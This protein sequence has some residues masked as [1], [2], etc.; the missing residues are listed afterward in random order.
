MNLKSANPRGDEKVFANNIYRADH[1]GNPG[2][3]KVAYE[4]SSLAEVQAVT[5]YMNKTS[6]KSYSVSSSIGANGSITVLTGAPGVVKFA[7]GQNIQAKISASTSVG[8]DIKNGKSIQ[9][10]QFTA[11]VYKDLYK[12]N[13]DTKL[14]F[15][16]RGE[17]L[18]KYLHN[19]GESGAKFAA[20]DNPFST[21]TDLKGNATVT[22]PRDKDGGKPNLQEWVKATDYKVKK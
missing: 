16:A 14:G 6:G 3:S 9:I 13:S 17:E 5:S 8:R 1:Y 7:T 4:Q 2:D 12:I 11:D 19:L 22:P 10:Q 18:H 20:S 21:N 15:K